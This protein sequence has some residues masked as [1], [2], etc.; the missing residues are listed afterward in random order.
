MRHN[1]R[2]AP[3]TLGT[4]EV[5]IPYRGLDGKVPAQP[6]GAAQLRQTSSF[7]TSQ[8]IEEPP[9]LRRRSEGSLIWR[10][11]VSI[12]SWKK[13]PRDCDAVQGVTVSV[14]D[15]KGWG[16]TT[17]FQ[18]EEEVFGQEQRLGVGTGR[19]I[20]SVSLNKLLCASCSGEPCKDTPLFCIRSY[21]TPGESIEI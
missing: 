21:F 11:R 16:R 8:Q 18:L 4:S 10:R 5:E 7:R 13:L 19:V 14:R 6:P 9:S 2:C 15:T 3:Q 17:P 1:W 12:S 20:S